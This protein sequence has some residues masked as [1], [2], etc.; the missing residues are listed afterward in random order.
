[1]FERLG[2]AHYLIDVSG[3]LRTLGV[4]PRGEAWRIGIEEPDAM[5]P[6]TRHIVPLSGRSMATS[7]DYRNFFEEDGLRYS[8]EIDPA[9]G[10]PIRHG[11]ASVTVVTDDCVYADAMATALIV[12]GPVRGRA[13]AEVTGV[14]AQFIERGPH[15]F[16]DSMTTA[17][18]ALAAVR[19]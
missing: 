5:P 6:R 18:A 9:S 3:E 1:V 16:S 15:G 12:L 2:I 7:G 14:A 19:A 13:L 11:L 10:A 17:F 8:H 4:N